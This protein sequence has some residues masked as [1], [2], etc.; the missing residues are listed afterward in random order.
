MSSSKTQIVFIVLPYEIPARIAHCSKMSHKSW[1]LLIVTVLLLLH[2]LLRSH[3]DLQ[4]VRRVCLTQ[5]T[6]SWSRWMIGSA[7][8]A[9]CLFLGRLGSGHGASLIN[10][11]ESARSFPKQRAP[12]GSWRNCET[13]QV[14]PGVCSGVCLFVPS[15]LP[16]SLS[17]S[18]TLSLPP[19]HSCSPAL[20]DCSCDEAGRPDGGRGCFIAAMTLRHGR[21]NRLK[22][23][24]LQSCDSA[25]APPVMSPPRHVASGWLARK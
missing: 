11:C 2:H 17:P 7:E 12:R 24:F 20:W 22:A 14:T 10:L 4:I 8:G 19:R 1:G 9:L 21:T 13:E 15:L 5:Q 23:G 16:P 3:W 6:P 18:L 25:L